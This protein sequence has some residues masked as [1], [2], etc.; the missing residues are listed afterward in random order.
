MKEKTYDAGTIWKDY[1][2]YYVVASQN[3]TGIFNAN[4]FIKSMEHRIS[5]E[6][7]LSNHGFN[8]SSA[9]HN[10]RYMQRLYN[11]SLNVVDQKT[12]EAFKKIYNDLPRY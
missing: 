4:D 11:E 2:N 10:F 5:P 8:D 7:Y 1:K 3:F 9:I 6:V 12:F